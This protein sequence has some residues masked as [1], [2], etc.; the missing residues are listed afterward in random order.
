MKKYVLIVA[1]IAGCLMI[2]E[3]TSAQG[4]LNKLSKKVQDKIENKVEDKVDEKVD[5]K[6]DEA[7][8]ENEEAAASDEEKQNERLQKM[9]KGMGLSGDPVP[10]EDSYTFDSKIQMHIESYKSNGKLDNEGDFVTYINPEGKNF[11]YEFISGDMEQKGKGMFIMD[12]TNGAMIILSDDKGEK[13]GIVYG[14]NLDE[15]MDDAYDELDEEQI[16]NINLNPYL[17]KT[18]RSKSIAGYTC[19]EYKYNNPEEDTEASFWISEKANFKTRDYM[20]S[21]FKSAAYSRGMP[22]G[23][24]MESES[25]NKENNERT[26]MKV[27]DIDDNANKKFNL[28]NYQITNLGSMNIPTG[29]EE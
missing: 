10:I 16:K 3:T 4:F 6:L 19:E 1:I 27:T 11:A 26:L 2:S 28:G 7:F 9:M 21:I 13:N 24:V 5:E 22:W 12:F 25:I 18:G 14:I 15:A 23:F 20:S 29:D 17:E 8:E